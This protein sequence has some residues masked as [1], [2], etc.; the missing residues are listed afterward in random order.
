MAGF[1]QSDVRACI[2]PP[3]KSHIDGILAFSERTGREN[4]ADSAAYAQ[5]LVGI[6]EQIWG[7][8]RGAEENNCSG[9][10]A[11]EGA[12]C[13]TNRHR[14]KVE[15]NGMVRAIYPYDDPMA[16]VCNDEEKLMGMDL[17]R[18][19]RDD[20]G[21]LYDI[22]VGTFLAAGLDEEDFASLLRSET[23]RKSISQINL[24]P[25]AMCKPPEGASA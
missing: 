15:L 17:N 16:I 11:T 2:E 23:R 3:D 1:D 12:L 22:V 6:E 5:P 18:G 21:S 19:L 20:T 8:L 10:G 24:R 4:A 14:L 25:E 7:P 9:G 13:K